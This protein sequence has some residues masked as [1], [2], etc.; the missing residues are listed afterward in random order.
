MAISASTVQTLCE[1]AIEKVAEG[2]YSDALSLLRRARIALIALPDGGSSGSN[3]AWNRDAIDQ[4]IKDIEA[5]AEGAA[6]QRGISTTLMNY[7]G[8]TS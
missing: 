3:L 7:I 4:A 1:Q 2:S 6:G 5:E 8:P